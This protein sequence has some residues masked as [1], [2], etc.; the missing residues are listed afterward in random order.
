MNYAV[1]LKLGAPTECV[2]H[3]KSAGEKYIKANKTTNTYKYAK[4]QFTHC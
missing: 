2:L 1:H 4:L 3:T